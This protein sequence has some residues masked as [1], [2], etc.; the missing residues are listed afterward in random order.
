MHYI[1]TFVVFETTKELSERTRALKMTRKQ[2][3]QLKV[4][5]QPVFGHRLLD[6]TQISDKG[7]QERWFKFKCP[8]RALSCLISSV[9]PPWDPMWPAQA[10]FRSLTAHDH[11]EL[12][13]RNGNVVSSQPANLNAA[14]WIAAF[15]CYLKYL[16]SKLLF[17]CKHEFALYWDKC[18]R[19]H[20]S[21]KRHREARA[22]FS[23]AT[24]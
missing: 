13:N 7:L 17:P 3:L 22:S 21:Q 23:M 11:S 8:G 10:A 9:Q 24:Y 19:V 6:R 1:Y 2:L 14:F 12:V 18:H 15:A 20:S 5:I 16:P 4:A